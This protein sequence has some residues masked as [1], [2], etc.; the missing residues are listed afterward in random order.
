M[1]TIFLYMELRVLRVP[2]VNLELMTITATCVVVIFY[3]WMS[4]HLR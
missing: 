2:I 1:A 4:M 3:V